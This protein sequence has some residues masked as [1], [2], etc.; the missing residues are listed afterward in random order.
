MVR[1]AL[2]RPSLYIYARLV[3]PT[4]IGLGTVST[5]SSLV[6]LDYSY[7][8]VV[9]GVLEQSQNSG[10]VQS[11]TLTLPGGF[12]LTQSYEYDPLN[13]L[14]LAQENNG[15]SWKQVYA[16]DPY[17]NRSFAAGTTIPASLTDPAVN[18]AI[19]TVTN[20]ISDGQGYGYDAA[21]NLTTLSGQQLTYDGENRQTSADSGG[22]YGLTQYRYDGEGRRVKKISGSGTTTIYVYNVR[23]SWW[24][25]TAPRVLP[26]QVGRAI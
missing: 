9:N 8:V 11:Q 26:V 6:Q 3:K 15:S 20:R 17:G 13:R 7:G 18:P 10:N 5:N 22:E 1:P 24:P 19:S 25:N 4:Q 14:K 16:Y 23:G 2:H 12:S 21:G